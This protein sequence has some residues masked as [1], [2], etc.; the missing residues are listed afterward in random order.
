MQPTRQHLPDLVLFD[1]RQLVDRSSFI[2]LGREMQ[3]RVP[4][5]VS[6]VYISLA[7]IDQC[8]AHVR[9][10]FLSC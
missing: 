4:V 9:V 1:V 10:A 3:G 5:V 2:S 8:D 6:R 7:A